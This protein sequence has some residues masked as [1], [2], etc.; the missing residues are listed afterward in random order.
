MIV[1]AHA[2]ARPSNIVAIG[3]SGCAIML[4]M[5]LADGGPFGVAR[6]TGRM[7]PCNPDQPAVSFG[8][9]HFVGVS[10]GPHGPL[11]WAPT[12]PV[13]QYKRYVCTTYC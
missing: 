9:K 6:C 3:P 7:G 12:A 5:I 8:L 10:D 13:V 11:E 4:T 1:G 2:A